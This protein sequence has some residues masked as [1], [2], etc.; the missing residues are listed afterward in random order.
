[1]MKIGIRGHDLGKNTPEKFVQS[2]VDA[3][4][5]SI[6]LV[7]PKAIDFTSSTE[8]SRDVS[9]ILND[10]LIN[11]VQSQLEK[12]G[13]TVAMMGAYFNPVHSNKELVASTV[14][15]FNNHL[16]KAKCFG[17]KLVGTE[18]GSYND[19]EW[20]WHEH[21][22][23]EVAFKEVLRV[24]KEILPIA[25]ANGTYLTIEPAYHHVISTPARLKRLV[26]ELDS[27]HVRVIF[28]LFNLLHKGNTKEQRHLIDEMVEYFN[29]LIMIV[30]AK[31]FILERGELIQVAPGKGAMDYPYLIEKLH[32]LKTTPDLILEGVV[33]E[34]I[35]FSRDFILGMLSQ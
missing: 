12:K 1:M 8:L 35:S 2:V 29:D 18:T 17:T 5:A 10:A 15:N 13:I 23:S 9:P 16:K 22:N 7:L 28:D 4:L 27:P 14:E 33:G 25:E 20:T 24:F 30:H 3:K 6:Q 34:D 11:E 31:D 26:S 32:T 19:D 21:N